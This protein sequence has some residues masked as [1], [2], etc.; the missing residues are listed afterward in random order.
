MSQ[1]TSNG[2][3]SIDQL[4]EAGI[5]HK[6]THSGFKELNASSIT[7]SRSSVLRDIPTPGSKELWAMNRCSDHMLSVK[8]TVEN[9][10]EAP[11]IKPY[12]DLSISPV[13]SCLHYA[14]Q[15]FE[16]MK[17]YR[18]YDEKLRLF[19][20]DLN[21]QRLLMS[22]QRIA[23]P[24][25]NPA[26][27]IK[28]VKAFLA[29]DGERWLPKDKPGNFLY[30]RPALIGTGQQVGIQLPQEALLFVV[31]IPWPD[32]GTDTPP[33]AAVKPPG[34]RLIASASS[35][36][37][38]WPGGF[39]YAKVGANYGTSFVAHSE[40]VA[41]GY[42]QIL[43]LLG[44]EGRVTEAGASN[45]FLLVKEE[46]SGCLELWTAPL[47]DKVILAGVTR[48]SVLDLVDEKLSSDIVVK[49]KNF[50]MH[51]VQEAHENGRI[52]EA[53]VSGTAVSIS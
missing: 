32:V 35:S 17:V 29:I 46:N 3:Q 5:K 2:I 41:R 45:F 8:W 31:A 18:G 33:G 43:W 20:P 23:L 48:K 6:D 4:T 24:S 19:R 34:L 53:F 10:W 39:G 11:E 37:R 42:D 13:A 22:A 30:V 40:A 1:P 28:L 49:E 38:A 15:C 21:A 9:G 16:G 26:E 44:D 52:V 47:D 50:T 27:F 25:F 14:T 12:A 36:I 7:I 51:D